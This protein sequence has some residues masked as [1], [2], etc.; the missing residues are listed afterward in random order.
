MLPDF[1]QPLLQEYYGEDDVQ[2]IVDGCANRR[3]V[4]LRANALLSSRDEVAAALDEAGI[5][6][7]SVPWYDDAFEIVDLREKAIWDLPIYQEGKVYLQSLSS[8]IPPIVVDPQPNT[9]IL[10]MCAAPGGKTT[11]MAAIGGKKAHI[12]AC[13]MNAV[14]ADKLEYNLDRQGAVNVQVMRT[15]ARNLDD[16]FSFD[17][18]LLDA[19]CS[20]SGTLWSEDPKINKRIDQRL[21]QKSQK[22][23]KALLSKALNVV[24]VGGTVIYSTCSVFPCENQEVVRECLKKANK[25]GKYEVEVIEFE[26]M[27]DLPLLPCDLEGA[28]TLYP[29]DRYEGFFVCKIKRKA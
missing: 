9:D 4:T 17:Q 8:M 6:W 28:L 27:E 24:K 2:R 3:N 29:T 25:R 11:Q 23:Q 13:E 7:K 21:I 19:P 26:G 18:V 10:D 16:F 20:G 22:S 5:A 15:D 12:T 14:R 1:F